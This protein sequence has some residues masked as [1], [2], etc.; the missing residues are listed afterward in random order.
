MSE[1]IRDPVSKARYAFEPDGENL[2]VH[3]WIE[4][5]GEL[6]AHFHPRQTEHWSVVE[7]R[8]RFRLRDDRRVIGPEDGEIVVPPNTVPGLAAAEAREVRLR[9]RVVPALG[10]QAFLEESAAAA[11][12]GLFLPGGIPRGLRG[13]RWAA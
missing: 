6:P 1:P 13:A 12:A 7:G 10:M 2:V 4:P 11:R 8:A 3:C 9:C 5:G